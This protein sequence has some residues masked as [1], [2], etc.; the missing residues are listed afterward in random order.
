MNKKFS[1]VL[2]LICVLALLASMA[3]CTAKPATGTDSASGGSSAAP[4]K[5]IEFWTVFT[6]PDGENMVRMIDEYNK[7]NPKIKVKHVPIQADELYQKVPTAVKSGQSVPDLSIVHV[8]R[9]QGFVENDLLQ[10]IDDYMKKNGNISADK[11]V[12]SA[13]ERGTVNGKHYSVPLDVH[14]FVT[15]YNKDLVEKYAPN[16]LADGV[17]TFDEVISAGDAAKKDSVTSMGI[18]WMRV[19]FLS[20]YDQLGGVLSADGTN[21]SFA[22][23]K[24]EKV[25]DTVKSL[26]DKGYTNVDGEDPVQMFRAGKVV[27]LPEG[28]W[29]K[30][31]FE[32]IGSLNFGMTHMITFDA[33]KKSNWTSSHQMVMFK[34]P[35]MN[36]E[37]AAAI[38]DFIAWVGENSLEWAKAGQV[39]AALKIKDNPE[40]KSMK[41]SFLLDDPSSLKIFEY[42]YFGYAAEALDKIVWEVPFGRV[43]TKAGL[44][45]AQK[46]VADRIA[47]K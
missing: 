40:F 8:E 22:N 26:H 31:S 17:V 34:N 35:S 36:D 15:Y 21:P 41:Q 45:Q 30:N 23:E 4:A 33:A 6:G 16:A 43:E 2:A 25:L 19:K 20:W 28:I 44:Q 37:R 38:M 3:A 29:M 9:L 42:K 32:E 10:P 7:T 1:K 13:W 27:F 46:E 5:D 24:A 39:P 47:N 18:T 11:Y 14:S 12:K